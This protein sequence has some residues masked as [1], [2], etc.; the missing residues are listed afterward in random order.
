MKI[1]KEKSQQDNM[2]E[3]RELMVEGQEK[4]QRNLDT[5]VELV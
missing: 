3:I 4:K 2:E 5:K 1:K